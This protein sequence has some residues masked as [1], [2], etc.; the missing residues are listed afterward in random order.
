MDLILRNSKTVY[1][2]WYIFGHCFLLCS[3]YLFD[4]IAI[5]LFDTPVTPIIYY[6]AFE[7]IL[8]VLF[9]SSTISSN[10]STGN[11]KSVKV[12]FVSG[13]WKLAIRNL[14][15]GCEVVTIT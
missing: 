12:V 4:K 9:S 6:F 7:L 1:G 8:S 13:K 2:S 3:H 11:A 5:T 10:S 14:N 15:F